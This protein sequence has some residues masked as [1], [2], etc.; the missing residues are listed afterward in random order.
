MGIKIRQEENEHKAVHFTDIDTNEG[1]IT[2][3]SDA[4]PYNKSNQPFKLSNV[5]S[6]TLKTRYDIDSDKTTKVS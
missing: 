4:L 2:E 5:N 3:V 6:Q 1:S